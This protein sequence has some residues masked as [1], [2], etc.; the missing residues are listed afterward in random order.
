MLVATH[1]FVLVARSV[2]TIRNSADQILF[3]AEPGH[4][5]H[6]HD[7]LNDRQNGALSVREERVRVA[8]VDYHHNDH[9]DQ[10]S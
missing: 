6:H 3:N 9:R 4:C 1:S 2:C 5:Y 10:N 7:R 8:L